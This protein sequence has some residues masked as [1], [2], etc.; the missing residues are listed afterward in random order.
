MD[1]QRFEAL[2]FDCY[3]TLI[4]WEQGILDALWPILARHGVAD[5]V[6]DGALLEMFAVMEAE[7][8]E[9]AFLRYRRVLDA[10]A[11]GIGSELGIEIG[12]REAGAFAA[13]VAVWSPF[14]DT[15]ASLEA[16]ATRYRLA[17]VS[18]VDDDL[19]SATA[20]LLGVRF[21]QVV[22][23][24]QVESYKPG[25]AHFHEVLTRL[26]LPADKVLHVAQSLHHDVAPARALGIAC[27][28]VNRASGRPGGGATKSSE[29][30]PD[31]EVPDLQTL[32]R[33]MGLG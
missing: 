8:E 11:R 33:M 3:G 16:L 15:V 21:D 12:D 26:C 23:A 6:R 1:F 17:V 29:V 30:V 31:L 2:T 5:R 4:D 28:W 32:V 20:A 10:V 24:E 18:N 14:P 22:T 25:H 9:R 7:A 13:S 27:V 19:F